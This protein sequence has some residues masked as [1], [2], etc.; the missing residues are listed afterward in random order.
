MNNHN[1]AAEHIVGK[2]VVERTKK[3][4]KCKLNTIKVYLA[5][6]LDE[7]GEPLEGLIDGDGE[8]ILPLEASIVESIFGWLSTNT[9]LPKKARRGRCA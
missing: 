1:D 4:Y 8:L 5:N 7:T 2:R 3:N 6:L 9:D